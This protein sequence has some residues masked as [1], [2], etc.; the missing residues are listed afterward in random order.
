MSIRRIVIKVL[1]L[2]ALAFPVLLFYTQIPELRYDHGPKTPVEIRGVDDLKPLAGKHSTFVAVHGKGDF[3]KAI[4][5]KT[6]GQAYLYFLVKSYGETLVIR[7]YEKPTEENEDQWK[8]I[9]RWVGRLQPMR[10]MAFK[11]TVLGHFQ[12]EHGA[13]VTLDGFFL[14]RDDVPKV[15]G[16]Q[17]GAISYSILLFLALLFFL[18]IRPRWKA[19]KASMA[20]EDN[21]DGEQDASASPA[22]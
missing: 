1:K 4:I 19:R 15:S 13:D 7:S 17:I 8:R 2:V 9:D 20:Q 18:F 11:G 12:R 6:H 21:T 10:K 3:D 22:S 16:W 5:Y 14:A